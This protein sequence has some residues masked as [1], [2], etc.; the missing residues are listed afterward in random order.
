MNILHIISSRGW[1]GAE[2]SAAYLAKAQIEHGD[3]AYFFIHTFNYKLKGKL[4]SL[5]VPYFTIPDPE[6]KNI[7][8]IRE[9]IK[10]CAEKK[11]D[12]IHTHLATA[13]YL[14]VIAGNYLKIP[15]VARINT[16]CGYPYYAMADRLLFAANDIKQYFLDDYFKSPSFLNY[17]PGLA[18]RIVNGLF[19]FTFKLPDL[20][21]ITSKSGKTNENV[22]LNFADCHETVKGY[23]GFFNIGITGRV[24]KEKGQHH[25]IEAI[26]LLLKESPFL[27]GKPIMMHIVGSGRNEKNLKKAVLHKRIQNSVKFWGYQK[28]VSPFINMFDI[29]ISYTTKEVFGLN[30]IE[31]MLMKKPCISANSGGMPELYGDTN[32]LVEPDNPSALKEA[33]KKYAADPELMKQEGEKGCQ[34]AAAMFNTDKIYNDTMNEYKLALK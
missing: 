33:I 32:V 9:I 2:N 10:I 13:C 19:G 24:T 22:P 21:I 5:D 25:L 17:K 12:I 6:R 28:D 20:S 14:G 1:G 4:K 34:R 11:I 26:D 23:E 18:E 15:A 3:N 7:F 27:A 16:Y 29:A 30:N 31:Y 8:A